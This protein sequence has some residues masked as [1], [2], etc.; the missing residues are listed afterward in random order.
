MYMKFLCIYIHMILIAVFHSSHELLQQ[1]QPKQSSIIID[2]E[3]VF[4]LD[5]G[6]YYCT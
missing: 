6:I 3:T 4:P 5:E 1:Q 2:K